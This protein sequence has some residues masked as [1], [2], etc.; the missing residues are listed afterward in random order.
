MLEAK[1]DS[2][3]TFNAE[4]F[5]KTPLMTAFI[6]STK[7]SN[8]LGKPADLVTFT[9]ENTVKSQIKAHA[10]IGP[11]EHMAIKKTFLYI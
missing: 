8:I 5:N 2:T 4:I 3:E 10:D 9:E 1:R 11:H 7:R 6:V